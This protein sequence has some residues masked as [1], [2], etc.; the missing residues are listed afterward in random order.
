MTGAPVPAQAITAAAEWLHD[1]YCD[2][3]TN[4]CS[5]WNSKGPKV[6]GGYDGRNHIG[7]YEE[8]A[9]EMLEAVAPHLAAAERERLIAGAA[10]AQMVINE[11]NENQRLRG[12]IYQAVAAERERCAQVIRELLGAATG[13]MNEL[14]AHIAHPP[15]E[16][17]A[18]GR[19]ELAEAAATDLLRET[20][21]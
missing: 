14:H 4:A 9:Q 21:T 12:R 3:D 18:D 2:S 5:R 19:W 10:E 8:R 13:L 11:R 17:A 15:A 20:Q 1:E 7:Y 16:L 6:P